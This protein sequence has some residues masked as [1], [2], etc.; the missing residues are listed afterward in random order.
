MRILKNW[1]RQAITA[2]IIVLSMLIVGCGIV[3][4]N[5]DKDRKLVVA[6]VNG[7]KILKAAVLDE[8]ELYTA[9]YGNLDEDQAAEIKAQ[10]LDQLVNKL[11]ITK[12]QRM[13][14]LY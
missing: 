11:I 4:V 7:E 6:E 10:I 3:S 9:L 5:E 2:M 12:R 13:Q 1:K 8:L 14:A